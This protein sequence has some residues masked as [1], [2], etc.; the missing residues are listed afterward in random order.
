[1]KISFQYRYYSA[2]VQQG[3]EKHNRKR[4]H[5]FFVQRYDEIQKKT[6]NSEKENNSLSISAY[7]LDLS[8]FTAFSRRA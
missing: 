1:M 5:R 2:V 6:I 8:F 4:H 3:D 7:C